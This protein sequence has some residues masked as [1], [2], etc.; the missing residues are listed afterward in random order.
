MAWLARLLCG[1][2][3]R[4]LAGLGK[5]RQGKRFM[6]RARKDECGVAG[7]GGARHGS[8]GQ[9][10]AGRGKARQGKA[11]QGQS[12]IVGLVYRPPG[13]SQW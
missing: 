11:R 12:E 7:H 5:A 13:G 10:G 4:G 6:L 9:G 3:R 8:A 2:A 1:R